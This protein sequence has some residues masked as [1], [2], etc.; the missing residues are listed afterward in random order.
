M[1]FVIDKTMEEMIFNEQYEHYKQFLVLIM[2][3]KYKW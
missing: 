2:S 3:M 1:F